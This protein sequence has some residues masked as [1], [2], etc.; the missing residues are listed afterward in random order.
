MTKIVFFL[1]VFCICIILLNNLVAA[2]S[3]L[4]SGTGNS[5]RAAEIFCNRFNEAACGTETYKSAKWI[6]SCKW[7]KVLNPEGDSSTEKIKYICAS[8][9]MDKNW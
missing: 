9:D 1:V 6:I 5:I 7:K 8:D 2:G 3:C 4:S